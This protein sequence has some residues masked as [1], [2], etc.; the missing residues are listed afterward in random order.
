MSTTLFSF[1]Q[2]YDIDTHVQLIIDTL[3]GKRDDNELDLFFESAQAH[4]DTVELYITCSI[5]SHGMPLGLRCSTTYHSFNRDQ[6]TM[7]WNEV[8]KFPVKYKDLAP[9]AYFVIT[10]WEITYRC[11]TVNRNE[12]HANESSVIIKP[13]GGTSIPVFNKQGLLKTEKK[14]NYF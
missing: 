5:F 8:L 9:D 7:K 3:Y 11:D 2:A 6:Y 12:C 14:K 13:Y 10:V 4:T 1:Y